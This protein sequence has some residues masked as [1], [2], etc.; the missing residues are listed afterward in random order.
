[1]GFP[2]GWDRAAMAGARATIL[3]AGGFE[4]A[5]VTNT[6]WQRVRSW[7]LELGSPRLIHVPQAFRMGTNFHLIQD[8]KYSELGRELQKYVMARIQHPG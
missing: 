5:G 1:M 4:Q 7:P 2:S 3:K 6:N 8:V